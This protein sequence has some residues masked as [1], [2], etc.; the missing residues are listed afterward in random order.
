[1]RWI[2]FA[3]LR[4]ARRGGTGR[5]TDWQPFTKVVWLF[6]AFAIPI[7]MGGAARVIALAILGVIAAMVVFGVAYGVAHRNDSAAER[8]P[9]AEYFTQQEGSRR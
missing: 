6:F 3:G 7:F 8:D 2:I 5:K 4:S 9:I 1:M